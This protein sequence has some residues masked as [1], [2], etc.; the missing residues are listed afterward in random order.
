MSSVRVNPKDPQSTHE[1]SLADGAEKW[2]IRL[3]EGAR[4]ITEAPISPSN[5]R[6]TQGG[7]RYGDFDPSFSHI[8]M[9]DW[10][11]GRGLDDFTDDPT[12]FFDAKDCNTQ[13]AGKLFQ[14]TQWN[15]SSGLGADIR[16]LPGSV[17]WRSLLGNDRFLASSAVPS[18]TF[19]V[20]KV[21]MWL[22][23]V[24]APGTLTFT[25]RANAASSVPGAIGET[26]TATISNVTDTPSVWYPFVCSSAPSLTSAV[27]Y[28]LVAA[29][30]A[31]DNQENHWEIG[32]N[33]TQ[34]DGCYASPDGTTWTASSGTMYFRAVPTA[35]ARKMHMF[36][37]GSSSFWAV[38][39]H[40]N[41]TSGSELYKLSSA[42][43]QWAPIT[44]TAALTGVVKDVAVMG[45]SSATMAVF[46]RGAGAS[47]AVFRQKGSSNEL[48]YQSTNS[49][50][51]FI[52]SFNDPVDG[53]QMWRGIASSA[54]VYR[55][56]YVSFSSDFTWKP[57]TGIPCGSMNFTITDIDDYNDG[58]VV[59]KQ[60]S[61]WSVKNDRASKY[62]IGIDANWETAAYTPIKAKDLY[63]YMAWSNSLERM[64]GGTLDD[65]GP[66]RGAGLPSSR[67]G[68]IVAMESGVGC[69][70]CAI[71]AGTTGVGSVLAWDG[72]GWHE[73]FRAPAAGMRVQNV[74]W[75]PHPSGSPRLWISCDGELYY[76]NMPKKSLTPLND[77]DVRYMHEGVLETATVDMGAAQLPKLFHEI[78][79]VSKNLNSSVGNIFVDYQLDDDIGSTAWTE[80]GRFIYSPSDVVKINR[81][82]K[83]RIRL[84]YRMLTAASSS[85]TEVKA[86]ALKAV[87]RTPLKRQWDLRCKA[88]SFQV[89]SLGLPDH[90]PDDFYTWLLDAAVTTKPLHMKSV[91]TALD[92]IWVY[93]EAPT[94]Q[95]EYTTPSGEWGGLFHMVLK[96]I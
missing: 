9:R 26:V 77:P 38:S 42:T 90:A 45:N 62:S 51:D 19:N 81:G 89:T 43:T 6:A 72:R 1:I 67:A 58:M 22:R 11:G 30:A 20:A 60:D 39:Q 16:N 78:H 74:K 29:G 25:Q 17:H 21:Y 83:Q 86:F 65:V 55:A 2:G 52:H 70:Y 59:R 18:T 79:C 36:H 7:T 64:Y 40:D 34:S 61:L 84:R 41:G 46:A 91:W 94:L 3:N 15:I 24:G 96:E 93:A 66:W 53:P 80:A 76:L 4:S 12:R 49:G 35:R 95:R 31:T 87:A 75:D 85:P 33:S 73:V 71:D 63:L 10:S 82:D 14:Q 57:S 44:C 28:W 69:L 56:D 27:Q 68:P 54:K 92:D 88:G 13:F 5:I 23:R 47:I 37:L 48:D 50:A 32:T 8:E